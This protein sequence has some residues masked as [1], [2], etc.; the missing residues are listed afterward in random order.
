MTFSTQSL[1]TLLEGILMN[2]RISVLH[3]VLLWLSVF[4]TVLFGLGYYFVPEALSKFLD[5]PTSDSNLLRYIGGF[6]LGSVVGAGL[7][8]QS[9]SW[10]EVRI[11]TLYLMSWN[12]LNSVAMFY[13]IL[14]GAVPQTYFPNA[15]LTAVAGIGLAFVAFQRRG[16]QG[17]T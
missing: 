8:L 9:G 14:S 16:R 5:T 7:A 15:A 3:R 12:L 4:P 6:L 13:G 17:S 2:D 11:V 1:V 10:R